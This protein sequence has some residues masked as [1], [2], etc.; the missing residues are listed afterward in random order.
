MVGMTDKCTHPQEQ[1]WQYI[2]TWFCCKCWSYFW[3]NKKYTPTESEAL[4]ALLLRLQSITCPEYCRDRVYLTGKE[5]QAYAKIKE[6]EE[7]PSVS[8]KLYED[9]RSQWSAME[10]NYNTRI[11]ELQAAL[12]EKDKEIKHWVDCTLERDG[13]LKIEQA[14]TEA[15]RKEGFEAAREETNVRATPIR[16]AWHNKYPNIIDYLLTLKKEP[17]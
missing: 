5:A 7:K 4:D 14:R 2:H 17:A 13:Y 12:S 15:A 1:R 3:G 9:L 11:K 10:A 6:L 8:E 16:Y